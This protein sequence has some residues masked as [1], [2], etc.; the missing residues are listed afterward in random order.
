MQWNRIIRKQIWHL[1]SRQ[2][3][4]GSICSKRKCSHHN[5][6]DNGN[7]IL[8]NNKRQTLWTEY[9]SKIFEDDH[10]EHHNIGLYEEHH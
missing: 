9:I 1:P 5:I 3:I 2:E 6:D 8:G 4:K 10:S 7:R